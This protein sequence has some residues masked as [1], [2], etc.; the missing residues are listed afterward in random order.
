VSQKHRLDLNRKIARK[1]ETQRLLLTDPQ[2]Q[3]VRPFLSENHN[4][5]FQAYICNSDD[6]GEGVKTVFHVT[7]F[8]SSSYSA[9]VMEKKRCW[10]LYQWLPTHPTTG[11]LIFSQDASYLRTRQNDIATRKMQNKYLII[12]ILRI[13]F[14]MCVDVPCIPTWAHI[15]QRNIIKYVHFCHYL[16]LFWWLALN[17][18]SHA[19]F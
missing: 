5:S 15:A 2:E 13:I 10:F 11:M 12:N 16:T 7:T 17:G 1:L 19:G 4:S 8:I 9:H 18:I 6:Q 3:Q 14:T